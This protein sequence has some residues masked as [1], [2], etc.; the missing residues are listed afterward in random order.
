MIPNCYS[1]MFVG[2]IL[3]LKLL[4]MFFVNLPPEDPRYCEN[5][6]CGKLRLSMYVTRDAAANLEIEVAGN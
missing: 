4:A 1:R 6:L 3:M 5:D 2:R